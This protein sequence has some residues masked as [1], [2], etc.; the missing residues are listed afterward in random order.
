MLFAQQPAW[1]PRQD[2]RPDEAA[3]VEG[4]LI[5]YGYPD[6]KVYDE[7]LW[8]PPCWFTTPTVPS[9]DPCCNLQ[10]SLPR[11]YRIMQVHPVEPYCH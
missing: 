3:G 11:S 2:P 7:F 10:W 6:V 8:D 1:S 4:M 5:H 9:F